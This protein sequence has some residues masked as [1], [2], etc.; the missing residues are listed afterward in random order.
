MTNEDD[1]PGS[2]AT[3]DSSEPW[4][5][6]PATPAQGFSAG[7]DSG[8]GDLDPSSAGWATAAIPIGGAAPPDMRLPPPPVHQHPTGYAIP[9]P[10]PPPLNAAGRF[11]EPV[12]QVGPLQRDS[13]AEDA[14]P[15]A[16]GYGPYPPLPQ[17]DQNPPVPEYATGATVKI[18]G[19]TPPDPKP[20]Q[21]RRGAATALI[22]AVVVL[23][24]AGVVAAIRFTSQDSTAPPTPGATTSS[25]PAPVTT[26]VST[27]VLTQTQTQMLTVTTR[28]PA[29]PVAPIAPAL[30]P[31]GGDYQ[32]LPCGTNGYIVQVASELSEAAYQARVAQV[33]AANQLPAGAHYL[34]ADGDCGL[35]TAQ[36]SLWVLYTGPFA[37]AADACPT[38]L[39]SPA[40]AFIKGTTDSS[41]QLYFGCL[42][43]TDVAGMPA[44]T[45]VGQT[46]VWVGELQRALRVK[47][48]YDV[49]DIDGP[50]PTWGVYTDGTAAAVARFQS[51]VGLPGSGQVDSATWRQIQNGSC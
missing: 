47:L 25:P 27:Q 31:M 16:H 24:A 9:I 11:D 28:Q 41:K 50:P 46:N 26:A 14:P 18:L 4:T 30:N 29:A 38:R 8:R 49:G 5:P 45:A 23:L 7:A 19:T 36:S 22:A 51:S 34:T 6:D 10:V 1:T 48:E 42:C 43:V 17:T 33:R 21:R 32:A 12:R 2:P 13:G 20:V 40:D 44:I 35:F 37:S 3:G 39:Q 15:A